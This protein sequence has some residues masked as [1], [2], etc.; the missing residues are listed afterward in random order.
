MAT[1]AS[2]A[3][4]EGLGDKRINKQELKKISFDSVFTGNLRQDNE[5]VSTSESLN[6]YILGNKDDVPDDLLHLKRGTGVL[7]SVC[8]PSAAES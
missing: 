2:L 8:L 3:K 7:A 6:R 5:L 4:D 1:L